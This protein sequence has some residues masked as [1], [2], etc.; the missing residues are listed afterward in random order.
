MTAPDVTDKAGVQIADS[1]RLRCFGDIEMRCCSGSGTLSPQL[2]LVGQVHREL[3]HI[4]LEGRPAGL[5]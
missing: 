1:E 3:V 4:W 2:L 5:N